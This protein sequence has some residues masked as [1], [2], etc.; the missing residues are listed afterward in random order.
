MD[1]SFCV[2]KRIED[3]EFLPD[4]TFTSNEFLEW[5][6]QMIFKRTWQLVP[7]RPLAD[8][9]KDGRLF[10]D[11][12]KLRGTWAT[13][14]LLDTPL[15]F[16]RDFEEN[17][18]CFANVCTHA[19][20]PLA[21]GHGRLD[22]P[23]QNLT[24]G[25]HGRLFNLCGE[26]VAHK[27][28]EG[29]ENFPRTCDNLVPVEVDKWHNFLFT[30]FDQPNLS[31]T[32]LFNPVDES[33]A[34]FPLDSCS[35]QL[36]KITDASPPPE[37]YEVEGNWK[38]FVGNFLDKYHI[39]FIH[40]APHGLAD[41][42]D[43]QSYTFEF[44]DHSVLQWGYA[45]DPSKGIAQEFLP[46]R[47]RDPKDPERTVLALWW[48]IFPNIFLNLHSWG[49]SIETMF[50]V[51]DRADRTQIATRQYIFDEEKFRK[52]V[53]MRMVGIEDE[54]AIR[55][56]SNNLKGIAALPRGKFSPREEGA[57]HWFHCKVFE[58]VSGHSS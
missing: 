8:I 16:T 53:S 13:T 31:L 57:I 41:A 29:L 37:I 3:A 11:L 1:R 51:R 4:W 20:Y 48:F 49:F 23:N 36:Q 6:L 52:R 40:R 15:L 24:C 26:F 35:L 21:E 34:Q 2:A 44:H 19:Y 56:V 9:S 12:V 38:L 55:K 33:L 46:D 43:M 18:H 58:M 42:L 32:N 47:F 22:S 10:A 5:E 50:P 39:H 54:E 25:Q 28:F 45:K 17:L 27:G 14:Q 7:E 30:A